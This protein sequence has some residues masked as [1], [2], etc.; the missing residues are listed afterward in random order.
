LRDFLQALNDDGVPGLLELQNQ[1]LSDMLAGHFY[2]T[3]NP[4]LSTTVTNG[5]HD[6]GIVCY[7][8]QN[9]TSG[10]TSISLVD[11]SGISF[12]CYVY[13]GAQTGTVPLYQ[14]QNNAGGGQ[15]FYTI[16]QLE[17]LNAQNWYGYST[18][19]TVG[20]VYD[21]QSNLAGTNGSVPL[22]RLSST[23]F[24]QVYTP[25]TAYPATPYPMADVDF[26]PGGAYSVYNWELFFH[27]P[28]LVAT[29]LSQNQQFE[30][31]QTWFQYIFNPTNDAANNA[32]NSYWNF[33]P[34]NQAGQPETLYDLMV[35]LG[36]SSSP[37]YNTLMEEVAQYE[38]NPF[39]PDAIARLRPA[40]YQKA[41]V[42]A[43]LDNLIAW[44][45]SLFAQNTRESINEATQLYVLAEQ[46]LG[47][48]P[49]LVTRESAG[50]EK[51]YMGLGALDALS[52]VMVPLENTFPFSSGPG[53]GSGASSGGSVSNSAVATTFYFCIP[54]N[55]QLLGY[56]STVADRLY[57]I[58]HCENIQ[59][60]V[61][62]LPL[63]SPPINPALLVQAAA[64]GVDLSS[65]LG[66][67]N[68][69]V[70]NYRFTTM[71]SKA[72]EL[73][74]EVRSLG[75]SLLSAL[76]KKDSEALGLLRAGQEIA[77]LQAVLLV[78]QIQINEANM[79]LQ[80][81][82][83]TLAVTQAK[84]AYYQGLVSGGLS[85][86]EQG[87][88]SNLTLSQIN[89]E[90]SQSA[91][92]IGSYLSLMPQLEIGVS[93][94]ASPVSTITF[95]GQQLSTMASMVA[96][97]FNM[98]AEYYSFL[99][100]LSGLMG[101]WA[102]RGTE[103]NFQLTTAGLEITQINDQINAANFR[104][105][106]AQQDYSNQ[107]LQITNAQ[108]VQD[109]LTGK[110]TNEDLYSWMI[111]QI[112]GVYFQ[113]YQMAYDLAKRAEACFRFEL[114]LSDSNYI[115]FGYWDG[116]KQGLL[117]G[118]KLYLD[119][120]R[121]EGAYLDQN[122]REYEITKPVSLV[123]LDPLALITLKQT[124]QCLINLPE[125]Y[126]DMDYPGHYL[127]RLKSVSLTIPC[128]T[129][130]YTTVN[131]T[132]TLLQSKIRWDSTGSQSSY[133][134]Q[135]VASDPR[136]FYNFAATQSIATSTAQNDSGLFEVNF[137]DERYLP[138]EGS[139][140]VSQWLLSMPPDSNAFDF[141]TITDVILNLKYTARDGGAALAGAAKQAAVMPGPQVQGT[142]AP[143][144]G[145]YPSKQTNL[146]RLFS[147]KHEFPTEWYQ[148][149][150]P[151][152]PANGQ[153][154]SVTL[155]QQRFPFQYRGKT[156]KVTQ[157]ELF[158]KF[159]NEYPTSVTGSNLTTPQN[160]YAG[161]TSLKFTLSP[162]G[163]PAAPSFAANSTLGGIPYANI[164]SLNL[165]VAGSVL[166]TLGPAQSLNPGLSISIPNPS[167]SGQPHYFLNPAVV[168]DLYWV[169]HYSVS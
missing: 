162:S 98:T 86:Q 90:L 79:N 64:A 57:K 65:V 116:L 70:P 135:P 59:G 157:I 33:L 16:S 88:I 54:P 112:S 164:T 129:G 68:A 99:A 122:K 96:Q 53:G 44:G 168:E 36:D 169:C 71:F 56:W 18:L 20:Y 115:Q 130:P 95:G 144:P 137:R 9:Q 40:A 155:S 101:G 76:E 94:I 119:L 132:L 21:P 156:L 97:A 69:A 153:V 145:S 118:E 166:L 23:D 49:Q 38:T 121:L 62:Q 2:T 152:T 127:R 63:F 138:F 91:G 128:V 103:W 61:Q 158:L 12:N 35:N 32:P 159:K 15:F 147:V 109:F 85:S 163:A 6:D 67:L 51:T 37:E 133:P 31:A 143:A 89:K 55:S 5:Y 50:Q 167:N 125:A 28:F 126:F 75:G 48:Q 45:D 124:G 108:A 134:E 42:M 73:C 105:Q 160:D 114:G 47:P 131:C 139:G 14:L 107:Q 150:N 7:L 110:F 111:G 146:T 46:I 154:L 66:D 1:A 83:D 22:Y 117:S 41:V 140:V 27:I 58:R 136:F 77:V 93:G 82:R 106:I 104:V 123:L 113:V 87:Q 8:F 26:T 11:P 151:A 148:F 3:A 4:A 84:Q 34:F 30:D 120:K 10:T 100:S 80:A 19:T 17:A 13:P 102:R 92:L 43:Y 78:K 74:A 24:A 81:L 149:L 165:K 39:D 52:D 60:Q 141:E 161:G 72:L 142:L 25:N 29:Q